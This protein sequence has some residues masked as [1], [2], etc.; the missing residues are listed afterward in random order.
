M[1]TPLHL[2]LLSISLLPQVASQVPGAVYT[3]SGYDNVNGEDAICWSA[4]AFH[5]HTAVEEALGDQHGYDEDDHHL[6][7]ESFDGF[8]WNSKLV[9]NFVAGPTTML[10][11]CPAGTSVHLDIIPERAYGSWLLRTK[12][13]YSYHVTGAVDLAAIRQ[14]YDLSESSFFFSSDGR[15]GIGL[16][17]EFCPNNGNLCSPFVLERRDSNE[18]YAHVHDD[19]DDHGSAH[20]EEHNGEDQNDE[21]DDHNDLGQRRKRVLYSSRVR[22]KQIVAFNITSEDPEGHYDERKN[23]TGEELHDENQDHDD[24]HQVVESH[25]RVDGEYEHTDEIL[26]E[27]D[28]HGDEHPEGVHDHTADHE[29]HSLEIEENRLE[30]LSSPLF[31]I[32]VEVTDETIF[33]FHIDIDIE[34]AVAGN[35][36]PLASFEFFLSN[37]TIHGHEVGMDSDA[38]YKFDVANL[39][40]QRSVFYYEEP[41]IQTVSSSI[42]ILSYVVISFAGFFQL[43]CLVATV[44]HR[45]HSVVKLSQGSFLILLQVAG[46]IATAC[47]FLYNPKSHAYCILQSPLTLIPLQFMLAIVFGRLRRII[48]IMEPL[49]N[50]NAPQSSR[51]VKSGLKAWKRS[52]MNNRPCS[53]SSSS[54][55]EKGSTNSSRGS[56]AGSQSSMLGDETAQTET[57]KRTRPFWKPK[58]FCQ[59]SSIRQQFTARRLWIVI[60]VITSP[61]VILEAVG[62]AVFQPELTL[63]MNAE[64]STG[65]YECGTNESHVYFL[66]STAILLFTIFLCLFEAQRSRRLPGLFNEAES[67]SFALMSSLLIGGLGFAVILVSGDATADPNTPYIMEVIVVVYIATILV[68]RLTV[69]K[70]R[71][72]FNGEQVVIANLLSEHRKSRQGKTESTESNGISGIKESLQVSDRSTFKG[73]SGVSDSFQSSGK[74]ESVDSLETGERN[75][76]FTL[77]TTLSHAIPSISETEKSVHFDESASKKVKFDSPLNNASSNTP[78]ESSRTKDPLIIREGQEPPDR[79]M[80]RV[81]THSNVMSRI[82]ER[83]LS[84]LLVN[85]DDWEKMKSSLDELHGLLDG[86]EYQ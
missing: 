68:V 8:N 63:H 76:S 36:L 20:G 61:L 40:H 74:R 43:C 60:A 41:N 17:I 85:R 37:D 46:I 21:D 78:E 39:L 32:P 72:I 70:L 11:S 6:E 55:R 18:Q 13:L 34:V 24:G 12:R 53:L 71:L 54:S 51:N 84:G 22:A 80:F 75:E 19:T 30:H 42:E 23:Q 62:M 29:G 25:D 14:V 31:L 49:M 79:L 86:V 9:P 28:E 15:H 35:Y 69:P 27:N 50:W 58:M 56:K 73:V 4:P 77:D 83:M 82:N 48:R 44:Y 5:N 57:P 47:S 67:V 16:R 33:E 64:Q 81:L 59:A 66:S 52:F 45:S 7:T 38:A 65:R 1:V 2:V 3:E 26:H 10:S